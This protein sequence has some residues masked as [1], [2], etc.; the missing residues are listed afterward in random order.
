MNIEQIIN[1]VIRQLT[2]VAVNKGVNKGIDL[3]SRRGKSRENMSNEEHD[4]ADTQS[5][6][7]HDLKKRAQQA[8]RITRRF[9]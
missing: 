9:F 3:A 4:R 7:G 8:N 1:M 2:R 6:Q 5:R